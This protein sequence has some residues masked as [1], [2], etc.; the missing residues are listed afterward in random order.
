MRT[1]LTYVD[2]DNAFCSQLFKKI[3][4]GI[5]LLLGSFQVSFFF[6][7]LS[8]CIANSFLPEI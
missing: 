1:H 6:L 4:C 8:I 5:L 7:N 3:V 2:K